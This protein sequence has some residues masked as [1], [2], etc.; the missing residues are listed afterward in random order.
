[1]SAVFLLTILQKVWNGPLEARWGGFADLTLRE[2]LVV[3]P[4]IVL[5]FVLGIWP[6]IFLQFTNPTVRQL[7]SQIAP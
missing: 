1:M 6:Q 3:V 7:I 4:A 2:R 5:M